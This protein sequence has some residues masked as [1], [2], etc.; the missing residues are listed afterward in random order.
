MPENF[1][2]RVWSKGQQGRY[3]R[4]RLKDES[5]APEASALDHYT[6]GESLYMNALQRGDPKLTGRMGKSGKKKYRK[7]NG[8][9]ARLID[10]APA[11]EGD[12]YQFVFR[13]A[14]HGPKEG[15]W[16]K[17]DFTST[18]SEWHTAIGFNTERGFFRWYCMMIIR[19][20]PGEKVLEV[21]G[22][23][24]FDTEDEVLINCNSCFEVNKEVKTNDGKYTL[25]YM[26][27]LPATAPC[28]EQI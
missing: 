8:H 24:A 1:T 28:T 2:G 7:L 22:D 3:L 5:S 18:T 20:P 19:I 11:T 14:D 4:D 13:G 16:H 12:D 26:T 9:L 23:S 15:M 27:L 6:G 10:A 17:L 21:M 25:I